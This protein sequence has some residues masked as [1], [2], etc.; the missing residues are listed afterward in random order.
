MRDRRRGG[1]LV[2]VAAAPRQVIKDRLV[3]A[4]LAEIH[5][6]Y[7]C[8]DRLLVHPQSATG[9]RSDA[10]SQANWPA[11]D[12]GRGDNRP[13]AAATNDGKRRLLRPGDRRV[14]GKA[15]SA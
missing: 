12:S 1:G 9:S 8:H 7:R 13:G 15:T 11:Q 5:K 14:G 3:G 10:D 4:G 6:L 2:S